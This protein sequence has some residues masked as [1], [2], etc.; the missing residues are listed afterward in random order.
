LAYNILYV[1]IEKI[2]VFFGG[3]RNENS[4]RSDELVASAWSH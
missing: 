4:D 3:G 2:T 1:K